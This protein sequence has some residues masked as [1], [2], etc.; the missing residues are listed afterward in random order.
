MSSQICTFLR[1]W[2]EKKHS[3]WRKIFLEN[4]LLGQPNNPMQHIWWGGIALYS[5]TKAYRCSQE[6]LCQISLQGGVAPSLEKG[7]LPHNLF[8]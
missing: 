1:L 5:G 6:S 7:L 8:Q 2:K 4:V 3:L